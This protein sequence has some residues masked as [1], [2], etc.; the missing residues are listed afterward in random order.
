MI[1]SGTANVA[2]LLIGAILMIHAAMGA[3]G[4]LTTHRWR[5]HTS[6]LFI[7]LLEA[8]VG[9]WCAVG[10][11]RNL[12]HQRKERTI[13]VPHFW[14]YQLAKLD[15]LFLAISVAVWLA[16]RYLGWKN[17]LG[18][19]GWKAYGVSSVLPG[20]ALLLI[21]PILLI[22]LVERVVK[23]VRGWSDGT[24]VNDNLTHL[25]SSRLVAV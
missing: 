7:I 1:R 25:S 10:A 4:Q 13:A 14:S 16:L 5:H 15:L 17:W 23:R 2:I 21:A 18:S 6:D 3:F 20:V 22:H 12:I 8:G 24:K 11:G 9:A 19:I